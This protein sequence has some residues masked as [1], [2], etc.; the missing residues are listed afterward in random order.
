[1]HTSERKG[2]RC[3]Q[4]D[5]RSRSST[6]SVSV[7]RVKAAA[8]AS[9]KQ[10]NAG[11]TDA[12]MALAGMH[13]LDC[14][15]IEALH[16]LIGVRDPVGTH[17]IADDARRPRKSLHRSA[18]PLATFLSL[19][20]A[21]QTNRLGAAVG[22]RM[23]FGKLGTSVTVPG[24]SSASLSTFASTMSKSKSKSKFVSKSQSSRLSVPRVR[25]RRVRASWLVSPLLFRVIV[26][27]TKVHVKKVG[28][29]EVMMGGRQL[30][31]GRNETRV[32]TFDEI[33]REHPRMHGLCMHM[34]RLQPSPDAHRDESVCF[35]GRD[36]A[37]VTR[38]VNNSAETLLTQVA[39]KDIL[40]DED[41]GTEISYHQR[42]FRWFTQ[43][44]SIHLTCLHPLIH[45]LEL[46]E[47]TTDIKVGRKL[48]VTRLLSGDTHHLALREDELMDLT[49]AVLMGLEVFHEH[50]F[51]HMDIKPD[52]VLWDWEETT[53]GHRKRVFC[54][55]DYNLIL[56][57]AN[58]LHYL[59]PDDGGE[60]Q[61]LSH[62]TEG[63]KSPL[64]MVDDVKGSTYRTF[65]FIARAVRVFPNNAMPNWQEY[66]DRSRG[67]TSTAKVDLH[68]LALTLVRLAVPHGQDKSLTQRLLKGRLGR[69][70]AKLMFFRPSD[71]VG[72][73]DALASIRLARKE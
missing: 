24:T 58:V 70:L 5:V 61:S 56:S 1:M 31:T 42:I 50:H 35:S 73:K 12:R 40:D 45:F 26:A 10:D 62:G 19:H 39:L 9:L 11:T 67:Q 59:R 44:N 14:E 23:K 4:F 65:E 33:A 69:L 49:V 72:A 22:R 2:Q 27:F 18:Y 46:D 28:L 3:P 20:V 64:L 38:Q 48:L 6:P 54:L 51:L 37:H 60:F 17:L 25:S 52:N 30:G 34:Y 41:A 55:S 43:A 63:Y 29:E 13:F 47:S 53:P 68:S 8:Y 66:F 71:F 36:A 57:D 32:Y 21:N 16:R 7:S 15:G